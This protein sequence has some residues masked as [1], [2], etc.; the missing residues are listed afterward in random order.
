[1][2]KPSIYQL[3]DGKEVASFLSAMPPLGIPRVKKVIISNNLNIPVKVRGVFYPNA[4]VYEAIMNP[5]TAQIAYINNNTDVNKIT[6]HYE[7]VE[8]TDNKFNNLQA[9]KLIRSFNTKNGFRENVWNIEIP[10]IW[11]HLGPRWKSIALKAMRI[12]GEIKKLSSNDTVREMCDLVDYIE[13]PEDISERDYQL[14]GATYNPDDEDVYDEDEDEDSDN[15]FLENNDND[16]DEDDNDSNDLT[17]NNFSEDED[18]LRYWIWSY[19]WKTPRVLQT[20]MLEEHLFMR[21]KYYLAEKKIKFLS[22]KITEMIRGQFTNFNLFNLVCNTNLLNRKINCAIDKLVSYYTDNKE[23]I[24]EGE[25]VNRM[26]KYLD[27]ISQD[28]EDIDDDVVNRMIGY[29]DIIEEEEDEEDETAA[30]PVALVGK[31]CLFGE[32]D[33]N[34]EECDEY[35]VSMLLYHSPRLF[36]YLSTLFQ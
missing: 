18:K 8:F 21:V 34:E 14:A 25:I 29:L 10:S 1:M 31:Y 9:K 4:P 30:E 33:E 19:I 17:L 13:P 23:E 22:K 20:K 5:K 3:I 24:I 15:E 16:D 36:L 26:V 6:Y 2:T 28:Y 32:E 11:E 12:P 27:D 35:K 7:N